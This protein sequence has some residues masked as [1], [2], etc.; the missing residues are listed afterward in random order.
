MREK[1]Q[2][3]DRMELVGAVPNSEVR[4]VHKK[5]LYS[6]FK[7]FQ[8]LV[9]GDIFLNCSLTEAFCIAIV[10]AANCGLL[11]VSTKV[12]GVPEVLPGHLIKL[13]APTPDGKKRTSIFIHA[14][15]S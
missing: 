12:G 5:F 2:L 8:V 9:R 14:G 1:Y 7:N 3:H 11:V 13:C 15:T 4:N 6:I 10:E